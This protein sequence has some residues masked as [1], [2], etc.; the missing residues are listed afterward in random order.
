LITSRT[1]SSLYSGVNSRRCLPMMNILA[2]K[3]STKRGEGHSHVS[4]DWVLG[5]H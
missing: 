5:H 1:A 4:T 2:Y 3:V